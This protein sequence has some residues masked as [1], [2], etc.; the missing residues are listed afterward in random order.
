MTL[1]KSLQKTQKTMNSKIQADLEIQETGETRQTGETS[2]SSSAY[3]W[4]GLER[5]KK[6]KY[7]LFHGMQSFAHVQKGEVKRFYLAKIILSIVKFGT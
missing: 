5:K 7:R 3:K 1:Q 6:N 4:K 2:Q